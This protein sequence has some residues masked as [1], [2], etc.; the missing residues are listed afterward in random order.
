VSMNPTVYRVLI[1][2]ST[3]LKATGSGT[4][5]SSIIVECRS[6]ESAA[7]VVDR[8]RYNSNEDKG[9]LVS[10]IALGLD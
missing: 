5:S 9:L 1:T 4:S 6:S 3:Y 8:S 7:A 10:A 2:T